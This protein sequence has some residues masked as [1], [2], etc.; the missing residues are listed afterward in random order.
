MARVLE[1]LLIPGV[2]VLACVAF[3]WVN[4]PIVAGGLN[5]TDDAYFAVAADSLVQGRGYGAP[6]SSTAFVP[7]DPEI[8]VGPV[9]I[10]PLAILVGIAGPLPWLPG[11][12]SLVLFLIPCAV[13]GLVLSHRFGG[14]ATLAFLTAALWLLVTA[15]ANMAFADLDGLHHWF[16]GILL[17]EPGA[18][19]FVL[20]GVALLSTSERRWGLIGAG[21]CFALALLTKQIALFAVVGGVAGWVVLQFVRGT[22]GRQGFVS[23]IGIAL[24]GAVLPLTFE[25]AKAW[26]LG[27][28][29][30]R[31]VT[32]ATLNLTYEFALGD[33]TL[34]ARLSRFVDVL[35]RFAGSPLVAALVVI[36]SVATWPLTARVRAGGDRRAAGTFAAIAWG[37]VASYALYILWFSILWERYFW[38]GLAL[39]CAALAAPMLVLGTRTR[40]VAI[41]ALTAGTILLGRHH[42]AYT[43]RADIERFSRPS[44]RATVIDLMRTHRDAT[45]VVP[46]VMSIFDLLYLLDPDPSWTTAADL[47]AIRGQA[48]IAVI[49]REYTDAAGRF[50]NTVGRVCQLLTPGARSYIAYRCEGAFWTTY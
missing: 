38:V 24:A 45:V 10:L 9:L 4:V 22:P 47:P 44:E 39:S 50:A 3:I 14:T 7:F 18:F 33:G 1:K 17:G 40:Q 12:L 41:A 30:Y 13:A 26:T 25:A 15:S 49:H 28:E 6:R 21:V 43:L 27:W 36:G 19:G 5:N 16:F 32:F 29:G 2:F 11:A 46:E 31:S 37:G 34:T 42:P 23:L 20:T 35:A 8:S 48:F